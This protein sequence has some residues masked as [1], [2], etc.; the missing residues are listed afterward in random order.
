VSNVVVVPFTVRLPS[1][2]T[3]P[4]KSPSEPS[5]GHTNYVAVIIPEEFIL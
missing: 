1:I 2:V 5:K 4:E 3:F